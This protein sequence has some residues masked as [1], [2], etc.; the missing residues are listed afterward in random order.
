MLPKLY[1]CGSFI[2]LAGYIRFHSRWPFRYD[3]KLG[4]KMLEGAAIK[5]FHHTH[6]PLSM[7][8]MQ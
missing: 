5:F 3:L 7:F 4:S 6:L 8:F 2:D 1:N